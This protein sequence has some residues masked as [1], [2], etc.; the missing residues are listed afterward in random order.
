MTVAA[1]EKN[2]RKTFVIREIDHLVHQLCCVPLT[3]VSSD[4]VSNDSFSV[5]PN[6]QRYAC[7]FM[8]EMNRIYAHQSG[9]D[10]SSS[11]SVM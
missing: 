9:H 2:K 10:T 11:A 6:P 4:Q 5:F 3:P 1:S 8:F 7:G